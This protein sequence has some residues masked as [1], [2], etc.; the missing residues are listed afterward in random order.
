[1]ITV[2]LEDLEK[3]EATLSDTAAPI[4]DR[5][6]SL[7]CIKA[8]SGPEAVDALV[9]SFH[10]EPKSE[11]LKHEICYCLGQMN[12]SEEHVK[13]MQPFLE[14]VVD[15]QAGFPEIVVHEAVEALGNLS[16]E[17]TE[18][19]LTQNDVG[20]A[21]NVMVEETCFLVK[22]LM[23]WKQD[24]K[25]GETEGLKFSDLKFKTNDPAPPY[26]IYGDAEMAA[27]CTVEWL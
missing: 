13:R 24:T 21:A 19:L 4:A 27:R 15:P 5:V 17:N 25:N 16:H 10:K 12:R 6:D 20:H 26:S 8:F 14:A 23:K 18:K 3:Y 11:L 9:R 2:D 22:G 1:M 7:F